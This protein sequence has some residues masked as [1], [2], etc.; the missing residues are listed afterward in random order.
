MSHEVT[1]LILGGALLAAYAAHV[2]GSRIHV[3]RV[4]LLLLI[5]LVCGP[6]VLNL[7][8]GSAS[9]AFPLV[10]EMAL[11]TVGFLLG[12]EFITKKSRH[13]RSTIGLAAAITIMTAAAVTLA[14]FAAGAPLELSLLLG[15]VATATDPAAILDLV[16][17]TR[18]EGPVTDTTLGIVAADDILGVLL[19][20]ILLATAEAI[21]GQGSPAQELLRSAWD[22][23]GATALGIAIGI[24]MAWITGRLR[25]GEPTTTEAIG[26]IFLLAGLASILDVSFLLASMVLGAT[27]AHRAKH[28][29]RALHEIDGFATPL[30][31]LFFLFA[32]FRLELSALRALGAIGLAYVAARLLGRLVGSAAGGA[33]FRVAKPIRRRLGW[34]LLPQAGV[35]LGLALL[36]V[37]RLPNLGRTLMPLVIAATVFFEIVGPI[38]ARLSLKAAGELGRAVASEKDPESPAL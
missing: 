23:A 29:T 4:T 30:M 14:T 3:P 31:A 28:H 10:A 37:E 36:A 16:R 1:L 13:G 21:S 18:A 27:V 8:Q 7:F 19:F 35:A 32:G 15:G 24:P 12:E 25:P 5:G 20:T 9:S 38:A 11:A 17:E 33:L 34:M 22:L 2:V 6:S 26:F